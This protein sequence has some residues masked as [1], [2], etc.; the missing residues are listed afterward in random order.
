MAT[1]LAVPLAEDAVATSRFCG[2]GRDGYD[3]GILAQIDLNQ[4]FGRVKGGG[5]DGWADSMAT[6]LEILVEATGSV[7][8]IR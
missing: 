3:A 4:I 7:F 1:G 5:R 2:G 6:G 8:S